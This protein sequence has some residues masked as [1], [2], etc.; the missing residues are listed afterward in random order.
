MSQQPSVN[1][2]DHWESVWT[3]R[4][5]DDVSWFQQSPDVSLELISSAGTLG[6]A[7]SSV[8]GPG[9]ELVV[10]SV[11]DIGGGASSLVDQLLDR[12]VGH[13]AV[14]DVS[15]AALATSQ[16]RLADRSAGVEWIVSDLLAWEPQRRYALWHDRAVLHFLTDPSDQARYAAVVDAAVQPG[17]YV[18][19]GTFALDGPEACSGLPVQ[20]HDAASIIELLGRSGRRFDLV[21]SRREDHV[22]PSG[23]VQKFTWVVARG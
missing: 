9:G 16:E 1:R 7:Q 2:A 15:A 19:I 20:R 5:V 18:V 21:E 17:G 22:T 10:D 12:G 11:V 4:E 3:T 23:A 14:L 8:D 13:V 6:D